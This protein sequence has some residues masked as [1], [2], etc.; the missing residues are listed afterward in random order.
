M[1]LK[2]KF[3]KSKPSLRKPTMRKLMEV[4]KKKNCKICKENLKGKKARLKSLSPKT[5]AFT[6]ENS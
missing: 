2:N 5:L 1:I 3:K 6:K 4:L